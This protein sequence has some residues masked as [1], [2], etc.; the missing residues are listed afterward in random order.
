[1]STVFSED[2]A[3]AIILAAG[4]GSRLGALN[5]G[6]EKQ[7]IEWKKR[8]LY[9]HSACTFA[10]CA[11]ITGLVF[12][13]PEKYLDREKDRIKSLY[14]KENLGIPWKIVAG[15]ATRQ[16]S[17]RN[18]LAQIPFS[19]K[20]VLIHDAARPFLTPALVWEICK[21]LTSETPAVIPGIPV[22]DTIKVIKGND[23][24]FVAGTPPRKNLRAIQT[25]QG[26]VKDILLSAY[27][28]NFLSE[29]TDDAMLLEK[30]GFCVRVIQG[31]E[32]N[33]K[34]TVPE[35]LMA[36]KESGCAIQVTGFGYDVHR[37]GGER[38]FM[39]GGIAIPTEIRIQAHSDGDVLLHALMDAI[40]GAAC[41]GDLGAHFPDTNPEYEAISSSLLLD[42]VLE[43]ASKAGFRISQADLTIVCQKPRILPFRIQVQ[44]NL[45]RLL[46]LPVNLVNLK[47]TTEE[48]LGF[49]GNMEGIK[50]FAVVSGIRKLSGMSSP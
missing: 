42:I 23:E 20:K 43:L 48:G 25:P 44:K 21:E 33:I 35:D 26:F 28:S 31:E 38:P 45:A 27:E 24:E 12:V 14:A 30:Q 39:L 46:E 50:A 6:T 41:L 37:Y 3:W 34:I 13:F 16:L 1:M 36:L 22:I 7:F 17:S 49:T 2:S 9:W 47:A 5:N 32:K 8:P 11:C 29:A 40:L 18:G 4:K 10:R 15:G 19:V